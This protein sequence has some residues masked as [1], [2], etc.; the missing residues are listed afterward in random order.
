MASRA[1]MPL[2]APEPRLDQ[3]ADRDYILGTGDE[4]T[5]RLGI[6]HDAWRPIAQDCWRRAGIGPGNRVL[7]VGAGPGFAAFDLAE[8]VG[9]CGHITAVERSARFVN[10]GRAEAKRRGVQNIEY[11]ELDLMTDQLPICGFDA[12][13]CRWVASFVEDPVLLVSKVAGSVRTDGIA[14][15]H[16]Y[17]DYASWRFSPPLPLV[18]EYIG[19]VMR[20]WREAG[21]E[22]N[23]ATLIARALAERGFAIESVE[24]RIYCVGPTDRLWRW[25]STFVA[26]NLG[27]L[28]ELGT[29]TRTWASAVLEEFR[30]AEADPRTLMLTPM[31]L[32]IVGRRTT[33]ASG[34]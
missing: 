31:V 32:E 11:L 29:C 25:I 27:R 26:S 15:F 9:P 34:P 3:R 22:P 33:G 4:E 10:A 19:N 24:P 1:R 8:M 20:S 18:E 7:D 28:V 12:A 14:I 17:V 6:Q 2:S 16:E 5:R 23:V 13:W 21:G 30:G